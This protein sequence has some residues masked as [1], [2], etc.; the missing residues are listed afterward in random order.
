LSISRTLLFEFL[1][2]A[3]TMMKDSL[4]F[5]RHGDGPPVVLLHGIGLDRHAW[6][7]VT[8][9]LMPHRELVAVDLPGHGTSPLRDGVLGVAELTASVEHLLSQLGL[10]RPVVVGNSLGV[11]IALE[12]ARRDRARAVVALSPIG[13]WSAWDVRY[14]VAILRTSR[15]LARLL[16][17]AVP[18]LMQRKVWRAAALGVYFGHPTRFTQA[19]ATRT[20]RGFAEAS[21]VRA[22]LPYSRRYR[23]REAIGIDQ[24]SVTIAWGTRDRLLRPRQFQRARELLPAAQHVSLPGSGHVPMIDAPGQVAELILAAGRTTSRIRW[25]WPASPNSPSRLC[26]AG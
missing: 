20:V 9:L 11:A 2:K 25:S 17:P 8:G 21:G 5:E 7:S 6:D 22:I 10:E 3:V 1:R 18:R 16:A 23:F 19:E 4:A 15:A 12:L 14:V 26:P 13:F 24:E